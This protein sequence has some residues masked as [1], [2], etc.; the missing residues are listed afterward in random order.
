MSTSNHKSAFAVRCHTFGKAEARLYDFAKE[1]FGKE[2]TFLVL[3]TEESLDVPSEFNKIIFNAKKIL[4]D[5]ELFWQPDTGWRCGDY[6][7]YAMHQVLSEYK[8]FW[9]AEPDLRFCN[10]TAADFFE[11]LEN[12]DFDFLA[13]FLNVAS[14]KLD[15][16]HTAKVLEAQPMSCLFPLTRLS[17]RS[18]PKLYDIRKKISK[19]F[20]NGSIPASAYPN[21]EIF[22]ATVT[23]RLGMKCAAI[24]KISSSNFL[25]LR[26]DPE[27][28][29]LEEQVETIKADMVMHPVLSEERFLENRKNQFN[30]LL[31]RSRDFS[32]W[33][34]FALNKTKNKD[35]QKKV[36]EMFVEEFKSFLSQRKDG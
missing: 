25:L 19:K 16:F 6:S 5:K 29:L 26:S 32:S 27:N 22:I 31:R 14:E 4:N 24:D 2:N 7:Y 18:V 30:R 10:A 15:F 1:Y 33:V 36:E 13:P 28:V 12:F 8:Y 17:T 9:L 34:W 23:R 21:D 3:N 35:V 11:E 20:F